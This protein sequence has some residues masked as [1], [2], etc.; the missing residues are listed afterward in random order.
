MRDEA[1]KARSFQERINVLID[2]C[3]G[4]TELSKRSGL[5]RRVIDK[6]RN[7]ESD[8]SRQRL[9]ALAEAAEVSI[10]WLANGE[11]DME[12]SSA[13]GAPHREEQST[14]DEELLSNAI[15]VLEEFLA[16]KRLHLNPGKKA[17]AIALLYQISIDQ[18][19]S[20]R[21]ISRAIAKNMIRL[22]S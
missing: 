6:Y 7:G 5:S 15:E 19:G 16:E 4:P 13:P 18:K 10:S 21:P 8:P 22:V 14:L 20:K 9:V 1:E 2:R 3:G 12:A 17:S 11:G